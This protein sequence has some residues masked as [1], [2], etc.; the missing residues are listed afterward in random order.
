MAQSMNEWNGYVNGQQSRGRPKKRW[1][2]VVKT[3]CEVMI[4]MNIYTTHLDAQWIS[5]ISGTY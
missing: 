3:D 2:D 5:V 1:P 4:N